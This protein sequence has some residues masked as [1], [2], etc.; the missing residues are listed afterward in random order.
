MDEI[1]FRELLYFN[2]LW[3]NNNNNSHVLTH[4]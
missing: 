2:D 4:I 3:D 1:A